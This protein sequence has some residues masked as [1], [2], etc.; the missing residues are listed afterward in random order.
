VHGTSVITAVRTGGH[1]VAYC[2][3]T[4]TITAGVRTWLV[5][6]NCTIIRIV[7]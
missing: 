5:Y 2:L 1:N 3:K 4:F 6:W 7:F